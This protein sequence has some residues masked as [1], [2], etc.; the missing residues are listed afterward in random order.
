[1]SLRPFSLSGEG[2][3][4]AVRR[5]L[6]VNDGIG[7]AL[8]HIWRDEKE[9]SALAL[10]DTIVIVGRVEGKLELLV[11]DYEPQDLLSGFL[12]GGLDLAEKGG[13]VVGES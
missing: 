6:G 3:L 4:R 2:E 13:S 1:L 11:A 7:Q 8:R 5:V 10:E 9:I 12:L